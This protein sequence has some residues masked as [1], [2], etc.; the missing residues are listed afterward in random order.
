MVEVLVAAVGGHLVDLQTLTQIP[1]ALGLRGNLQTPQEIQETLVL[2]ET[3]VTHL[4]P[5]VIIFLVAMGDQLGMPE[6]AEQVAVEV[7]VDLVEE[8]LILMG[9][10][11]M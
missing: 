7:L 8:Q 6:Q 3:L 11:L 9:L 4:Q 2:Q 5:L 1:E 10:A